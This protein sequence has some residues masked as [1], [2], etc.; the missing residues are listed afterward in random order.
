LLRKGIAR[1]EGKRRPAALS[2][3]WNPL[4]GGLT[5]FFLVDEF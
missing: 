1:R 3:S 4:R 2:R 5:S